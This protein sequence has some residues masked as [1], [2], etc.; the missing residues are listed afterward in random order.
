[1]SSVDNIEVRSAVSRFGLHIC[2]GVP[3]GL[4]AVVLILHKSF[5]FLAQPLL[6]GNEA[7]TVGY[8]FIAV[9][10]TDA[11][12]AY[13]LKRRLINAKALLARYTLHPASFARQLTAAYAPVF[14][15][16]A[17]PAV[18][19]MICYFLCSD[20]DTYILISVICPAS[21]LL[22]KPKEVEIDKLIAEIFTPTQDSDLHL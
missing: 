10:V 17:M 13:V 20:L 3:V 14:T 1:M 18:Y 5:N 22:L 16:C 2:L 21:Y 15:V 9:A 4:L 19:G 8:V 11:L 7:K 12:V 6:T